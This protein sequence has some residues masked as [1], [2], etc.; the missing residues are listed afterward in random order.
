MTNPELVALQ[1]SLSDLLTDAEDRAKDR[2]VLYDEAMATA[3]AEWDKADA[4]VREYA[5][6]V[7]EGLAPDWMV[8][9]YVLA[10]HRKNRLQKLWRDRMESR[11]LAELPGS[12]LPPSRVSIGSS[13]SRI[14]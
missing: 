10:Q 3:Q 11:A 4:L 6:A 14:E 13:T 2:I 5:P 7:K 9:E 12:D 1:R 8:R